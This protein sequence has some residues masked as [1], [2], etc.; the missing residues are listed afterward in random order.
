[1]S[2]KPKAVVIICLCLVVLAVLAGGIIIIVR[3]GVAAERQ[4]KLMVTMSQVRSMAAALRTFHADH[5]AYPTGTAEEILETLQGAN[6]RGENPM[7]VRYLVLPT[8]GRGRA[9][10]VWEEPFHLVPPAPGTMPV[11]FSS[12]PNRTV[13]TGKTSSDDIHP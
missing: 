1:M 6:T 2:R 4:A 3:T 7:R 12:G 8:T 11:F 10:D 13:D 9:L 5:G